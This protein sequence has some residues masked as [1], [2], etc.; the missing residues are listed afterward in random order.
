MTTNETSEQIQIQLEI[1]KKKDINI[2]IDYIIDTSV[3]YLDATIT[4]ENGH[5][6]TCVYHKKNS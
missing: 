2:D 1:A 5:L 3:N 4:N 6:R